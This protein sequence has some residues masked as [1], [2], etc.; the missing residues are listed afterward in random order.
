MSQQSTD[1]SFE[2]LEY[3]SSSQK[4]PQQK[5]PTSTQST[6][7]AT[8]MQKLAEQGG[9][10]G[11]I[12]QAKME[13][14][15]ASLSQQNVDALKTD[16][17]LK[18]NPQLEEIRNKLHFLQIQQRETQKA[19]EERKQEED[20]RKQLLEMEEDNKLGPGENP[21]DTLVLPKGKE[22]KSIFGGKKKVQ[23]AQAEYKPGTSKF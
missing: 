6:Q 13:A 20:E 5:T 12:T 21:L 15:V 16:H 7:A 4:K 19:I 10:E 18:D 2:R 3:G 9:F 17:S 23:Q 11:E 1:E 22:R 8:V 14:Q